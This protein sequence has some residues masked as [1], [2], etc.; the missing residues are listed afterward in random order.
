[1]DVVLAHVVTQFPHH[2]VIGLK[3]LG[4]RWARPEIEAR[5][6][7][8]ARV[9]GEEN[10]S[11]QQGFLELAQLRRRHDDVRSDAASTGDL[12]AAVSQLDF[13]WMLRNF[14]LVVILIERNRLVIAL[15]QATARRVIASG[16]QCQTGV[17]AKWR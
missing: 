17:L 9:V 10:V 6:T 14:A 15:D 2:R 13:R 4:D 8:N 3:A 11:A 5:E 7:A 12:P 1:M 16:C